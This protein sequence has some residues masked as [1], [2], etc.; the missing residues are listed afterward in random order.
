MIKY[1][2]THHL[3]CISLCFTHRTQPF[4]AV[5]EDLGLTKLLE[6]LEQRGLVTLMF[7]IYR[8]EVFVVAELLLI[9][10]WISQVVY[11]AF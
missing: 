1:L 7:D 8:L 10:N 9:A 6:T 11:I 4:I 3:Y 2:E 5:D